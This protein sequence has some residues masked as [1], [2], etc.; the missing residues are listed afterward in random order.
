LKLPAVVINILVK[1]EGCSD[2]NR[3]VFLEETANWFTTIWENYNSDPYFSNCRQNKGHE[4]ADK[5]L[6]A[7]GVPESSL[8]SSTASTIREQGGSV[9]YGLVHRV[10][11]SL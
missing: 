3:R 5:I 10:Q 9:V 7:A 4:W 6:L 8:P 1:S 2:P 11:K